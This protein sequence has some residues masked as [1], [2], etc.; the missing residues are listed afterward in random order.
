MKKDAPKTARE[1]RNFALVMTVGLGI[2]GGLL[3]WKERAAA[4]YFLGVAA[5]FLI[6]GLLFP[7]V[8]RPLEWA[9]MKLAL[10]LG[11]IMT[12]II[13]NLTFFLV[14]TPIGLVMRLFGKRP[15]PLGFDSERSSFWEPVEADGPWGRPD[16]PY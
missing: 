12:F 16:K 2:I 4:P 8:L 15:L 10:L 1:L 7:K 9:W 5:G 14:I 13:L 11:V 6:S 3:L